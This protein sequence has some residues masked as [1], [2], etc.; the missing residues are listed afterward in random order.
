MRGLGHGGVEHRAEGIECLRRES[1][2][3]RH[4]DSAGRERVRRGWLRLIAIGNRFRCWP[5]RTTPTLPD[6]ARHDTRLVREP[7]WQ[8]NEFRS[9]FPECVG[10]QTS[11]GVVETPSTRPVAL[12]EG[13]MGSQKG[14]SSSFC[15]FNNR[16]SRFARPDGS[17]VQKSLLRNSF[18][19]H[20][21]PQD[22]SETRF[23]ANTTLEDDGQIARR[24]LPSQFLTWR[25]RDC[26]WVNLF[27]VSQAGQ[28]AK[29]LSPAK[30]L[31][32]SFT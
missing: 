32:T 1:G 12:F 5:S 18:G 11:F 10:K 20:R 14:R 3:H 16:I 24:P 6:G 27:I 19:C 13:N 30:T 15:C 9:S 28:R 29:R 2:G 21:G 4:C 25:R 31:V 26:G 22:Y 17:L 23:A 8:Q 7:F